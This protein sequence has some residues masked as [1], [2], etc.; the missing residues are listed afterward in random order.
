MDLDQG[1]EKL[2]SCGMPWEGHFLQVGE[3]M[4]LMQDV[5]H[6]AEEWSVSLRVHE[7][8]LTEVHVSELQEKRHSSKKRQSTSKKKK[9]ASGL[10]VTS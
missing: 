2:G 4:D 10:D 7:G 1:V 8:A 6:H 5:V 3:V 9:L